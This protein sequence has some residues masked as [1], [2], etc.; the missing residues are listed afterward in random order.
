[1]LYENGIKDSVIKAGIESPGYRQ[2]IA[3]VARIIIHPTMISAPPVAHGGMEANTGAKKMETK[4]HSAV[5]IEVRPVLPP[6]IIPAPLSM[7]ATEGETP[8]NAPTEIAAASVQY[9]NVDLSKSPV[10]GLTAPEK[11]AMLY[12]VPVQSKIST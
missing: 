1:M 12:R 3:S 6:S 7:Y 9:A 5:V 10:S 4:K 11:R 8:N 2:F